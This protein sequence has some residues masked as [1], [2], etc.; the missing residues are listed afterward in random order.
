MA[1]ARPLRN[2]AVGLALLAL[3]PAGR[4]W[5]DWGSAGPG[6]WVVLEQWEHGLRD[7]RVERSTPTLLRRERGVTWFEHRTGDGV[8]WTDT[9]GHDE[10]DPAAPAR[11]RVS[12]RVVGT[13]TLRLDGRD[14]R[15]RVVLAEAASSPFQPDHPVREWVTRTR[16]WVATDSALGGRVLRWSDQGTETRYRDGRRERRPGRWTASVKTLHESVRVR[17]RPFDCW[18]VVR[19]ELTE[20]GEFAR[21]TTVWRFEGVPVGWLR[22][23]TEARDPRT[24]AMSRTE[25]RLADFRY[26]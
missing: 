25:E 14:V 12:E 1:A 21:R 3:A 23:L 9:D 17:G 13:A 24:G 26:E 6:S 2:V 8:L 18:V 11:S 19:K 4:A 7:E 5:A 10:V 15:C 20:S 22:R 16:R